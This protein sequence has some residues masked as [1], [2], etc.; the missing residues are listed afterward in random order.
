MMCMFQVPDA[1][2]TT[3]HETFPEA[4]PMTDDVLLDECTGILR[5]VLSHAPPIQPDHD[6]REREVS[7]DNH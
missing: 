1:H 6:N 4:T 2:E 5:P 7:I 3:L